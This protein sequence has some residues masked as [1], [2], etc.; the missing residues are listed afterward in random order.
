MLL[1]ELEIDIQIG[2]DHV[3][4][5]VWCKYPPNWRYK[6]F[7]N[8]LV[9]VL[10]VCQEWEGSYQF[11]PSFGLVMKCGVPSFPVTGSLVLRRVSMV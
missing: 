8:G 7:C 4:H 1:M 10:G 3:G 6:V 5:C 11:P 2:S 9:E